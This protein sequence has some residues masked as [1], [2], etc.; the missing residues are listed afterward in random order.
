MEPRLPR[1]NRRCRPTTVWVA[2]L[3]AVALAPV[4]VLSSPFL[5]TAVAVAQGQ[6]PDARIVPGVRIGPVDL[7]GLDLAAAGQALTNAY[8]S[9]G[10]GSLVVTAGAVHAS[11]SYAQLGRRLDLGATL[12]EAV[13][14][15]RQGSASQRLMAILRSLLLGIRFQPVLTLDAAA[16]AAQLDQIASAAHV[17]PSDAQALPTAGGF[18]TAPAV[19]GQ[20]FDDTSTIAALTTQLESPTASSTLAVSMRPTTTQPAI[21]DDAAQLARAEAAVMAQPVVLANAGQTWTFPASVVHSWIG[22]TTAQGTIQPSVDRAAIVAALAPLRSKINRGPTSASWAFG[23]QGVQVVPSR[24]GRTLDVGGTAD[25]VVALLLGRGLSGVSA[26]KK[27]GLAITASLPRFTTAQAQ[28]Q[29]SK[30]TLLSTWTTY[31]QLG[32][33]NGFGANIWI[34]AAAINGQVVQPGQTFN[35][36]NAVGPVTLAKGYTMGG[37][38]INGHTEE[39]AAL[40]GGICATSTTLFNAALRAG[41]QMG[42]RSNHYYYITRYPVGLDAT[43]SISGN[44]VQNMTWVNDSPNPVLIEGFKGPGSVTFSLYGVPTGRTV[45]FS[46]P[47]ITNYTTSTTQVIHTSALPSGQQV[48]VEYADDGFDASV[49]RTVRDASGAIIHQET[50]YS[51]YATMTGLIYVGDP[52][53]KNIPIPSYGP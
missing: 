19:V 14:V 11:V 48:Q 18:T 53:A 27:Q 5:V 42:D 47:I 50:Y 52:A 8:G 1:D 38:I 13:N 4:T 22:F 45:T 20:Q 29:A 37:A 33:H 17:M 25:K 16:L 40:G 26:G 41:F 9:L 3:V 51:N 31:F 32:A 21:T 35:F 23:P 28:G 44:S 24:D 36:W 12:Q 30:F 10:Q 43:V 7:S 15:G 39:G 49:T 6:A 2:I 46:Q 34:P